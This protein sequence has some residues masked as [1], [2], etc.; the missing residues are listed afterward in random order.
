LPSCALHFCRAECYARF[1]LSSQFDQLAQSDDCLGGL[2]PTKI[3]GSERVIEFEYQFWVRNCCGL[4][5]FANRDP[6]VPVRCCKFWIGGNSPTQRTVESK[7]VGPL[8]R[9]RR[10]NWD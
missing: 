4:P 10:S 2:Q 7:S 1:A 6:D 3:T 8:L 5:M 9:Q